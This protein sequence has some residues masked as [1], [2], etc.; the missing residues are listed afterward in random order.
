MS[1]RGKVVHDFRSGMFDGRK[2]TVKES[3]SGHTCGSLYRATCSRC[4]PESLFVRGLCVVCN[5]SPK[6][7]KLVGRVK[8]ATAPRRLVS[9]GEALITGAFDKA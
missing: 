6:A 9:V 3:P 8:P 1:T 2:T 5:R 7:P 4:G